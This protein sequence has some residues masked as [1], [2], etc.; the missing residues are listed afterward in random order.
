MPPKYAVALTDSP[1]LPLSCAALTGP[2]VVGLSSSPEDLSLSGGPQG[3]SG[4]PQQADLLG[5]QEEGERGQSSPPSLAGCHPS[6]PVPHSPGNNLGPHCRILDSPL[7]FSSLGSRPVAQSS[8]L[9]WSQRE[10]LSAAPTLHAA[11]LLS[12]RIK[13]ITL[14]DEWSNDRDVSVSLSEPR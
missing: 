10:T 3:P 4:A 1:W 2:Q 8:D 5:C 12:M 14:V 7:A 9:H 6:W 13:M 11:L